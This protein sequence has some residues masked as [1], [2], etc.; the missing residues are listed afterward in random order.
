LGT[1]FGGE[2]PK[3]LQ[4]VE[5]T[6]LFKYS[7]NTFMSIA[8]VS[9]VVL[10]C[11]PEWLDYFYKLELSSK[12]KIVEGGAQ[13]W[14]SV[15]NGVS[16]LSD[17]I[18]HVLVH[19]IARPFISVEIVNQCIETLKQ[20]QAFIVAKPVSDTVK[21]VCNGKIVETILREELFLAQTPQGCNKE[22][23]LKLYSQMKQYPEFIPT[24]ESSILEKFGIPVSIIIGNRENDKL[25]EPED[26][27]YF[28]M[29]AQKRS[30]QK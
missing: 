26:L 30:Y 1:R 3:Q 5:G 22:L 8:D 17:D 4:L 28:E 25:T 12:I 20:S 9:E 23:L 29:L 24:D 18:T 7:L 6:E 15:Y 21:K 10:V 2:I 13:R 11:H 19:D 27:I 14:I 16:A